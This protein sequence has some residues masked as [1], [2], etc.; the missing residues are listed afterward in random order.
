M[1]ICKVKEHI[2]VTNLEPTHHRHSFG[3]VTHQQ[4]VVICVALELIII[5]K[6]SLKMQCYM[7][8]SPS[9]IHLLRKS[10]SVIQTYDVK[11]HLAQELVG[12]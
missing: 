7:T 5:F 4:S 12:D 1:S 10:C 3:Q 8:M 6:L 9:P 11:K 2:D